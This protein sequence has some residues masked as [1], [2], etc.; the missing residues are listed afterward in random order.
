MAPRM[1]GMGMGA[2]GMGPGVGRAG[3]R[4][5]DSL[6]QVIATTIDPESWDTNG[7]NG[8]VVQYHELLVVKNSQAVHGKIK[9]LLEMMRASAREIPGEGA[10]AGPLEAPPADAGAPAVPSPHAGADPFGV[11]PPAGGAP[12]GPLPRTPAASKN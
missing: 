12:A 10:E 4:Q 3:I 9:A 1:G 7:G 8:S 5:T 2:M 11:A 6:A